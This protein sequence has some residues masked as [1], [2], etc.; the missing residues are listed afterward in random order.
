MLTSTAIAQSAKPPA[1][2]ETPKAPAILNIMLLAVSAAGV[3]GVCLIPSKRG[4]Q[5]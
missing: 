5:D 1:P 4:H 2:K 3:I